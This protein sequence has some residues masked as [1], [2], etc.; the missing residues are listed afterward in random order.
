MENF[1][2]EACKRAELYPNIGG[3]EKE[4]EEIKEKLEVSEQ[5]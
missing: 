1:S 2:I 4:T 3:Y 5:R